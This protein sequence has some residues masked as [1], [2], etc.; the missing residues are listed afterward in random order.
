LAW[1]GS[2]WARRNLHVLWKSHTEQELDN[3]LGMLRGPI[4]ITSPEA[5][6]KPNLGILKKAIVGFRNLNADNHT[7]THFPSSHRLPCP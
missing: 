6:R 1:K 4:R 5:I 3:S 7:F 2:D